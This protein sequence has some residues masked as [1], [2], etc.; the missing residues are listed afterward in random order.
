MSA[1]IVENFFTPEEACALN[2]PSHEA[3]SADPLVVLHSS[4]PSIR[5]AMRIKQSVKLEAETNTCKSPK[6]LCRMLMQLIYSKDTDWKDSSAAKF[7]TDDS[8]LIRACIGNYVTI[9][10]LIDYFDYINSFLIAFL[11]TLRA[12]FT[13]SLMKSTLTQLAAEKSKKRRE[14]E[15]KIQDRHQ[16]NSEE[17]LPIIGSQAASGLKRTSDYS[18]SSDSDEN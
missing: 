17:E 12:N 15:K 5:V 10:I 18:T 7:F 14:K 13:S 6:A 16:I 8:D 4:Y 9:F 3:E 1:A 11:A 2:F